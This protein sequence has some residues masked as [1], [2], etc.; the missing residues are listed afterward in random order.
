MGAATD[1][2]GIQAHILHFLT[3]NFPLARLRRP[4]P[5]DSLLGSGIIDSL[6]AISVIAFLE[7]AYPIQFDDDDLTAENFDSLS[8]IAELV[9]RKLAPGTTVAEGGPQ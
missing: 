9:Q 8:G 7:S 6:G 5:T 3:G 4:G 1:D 2:K